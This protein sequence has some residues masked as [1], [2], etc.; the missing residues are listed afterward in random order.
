MRAL[1]RA[2]LVA[3]REGVREILGRVAADDPL[4]RLALQARLDAIDERLKQLGDEI[5]TTGSVALFFGGGPVTGSLG[6]DAS[7]AAATIS[8]FRDLVAKKVAADEVGRL[9]GRGP[10]PAVTDPSL[11]ITDVVRG[12]FGFLVREIPPTGEIADTNVKHAMD[13]VTGLISR[14]ASPDEN[15]F[16]EEIDGVD[17]R[18]LIPLQS[19]FRALDE[20]S[21]T[22]RIVDEHR[23]EILD[24]AAVRRGRARVDA[25][26]V[27]E[28]DSEDFTGEL[29]GVLPEQRRF[30]MRLS[31][32]GEII[33][34]SVAAA[35]IPRY[36]DLLNDPNAD[37]PLRGVW[38]V[39]MRVR[40]IRQ[41]NK[42]P[43]NVY[44]LLGLLDR[45]R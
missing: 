38:R 19:F 41:R 22:V 27:T 5:E 37:S 42:E 21:A 9:G 6:I 13:A 29:Q 8:S 35:L 30:E 32:S 44:T 16:E 33:R 10:L 25:T 1:E 43:R 24:H 26:E 18:F 12:S 45:I 34:G 4:G 23:D 20:R 40:T 14:A 17:P 3:D 31:A 28:Q 15:A 2:S 39:K 7:F 11:Y 36:R